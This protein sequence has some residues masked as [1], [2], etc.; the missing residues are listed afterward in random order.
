MDY[1]QH[2][3]SE[4]EL[5]EKRFFCLAS[6]DKEQDADNYSRLVKSLI[7]LYLHDDQGNGH[8]LKHAAGESSQIPDLLADSCTTSDYTKFF[9]YHDLLFNLYL[10]PADFRA[11]SMT[12]SGTV[13][14]PE[15]YSNIPYTVISQ[16]NL[17]QGRVAVMTFKPN[18]TIGQYA[19]LF[20]WN[21]APVMSYYHG[22]AW[23]FSEIFNYEHSG[24]PFAAPYLNQP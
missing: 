2:L 1:P 18:G 23:P 24:C 15:Q 3:L 9:S 14:F 13:I 12:R 5:G 11:V 4:V 8:P 6:V 7:L 20:S 10:H 17:N 21:F 22:L 19:N 16:D